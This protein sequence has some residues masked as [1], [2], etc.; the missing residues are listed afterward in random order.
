[1]EQNPAENSA[2][3][4]N[5]AGNI[6]DAAMRRSLGRDTATISAKSSPRPQKTATYDTGK[7]RS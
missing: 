5:S 3:A 4:I 7:F 6:Q 2:N 1:M